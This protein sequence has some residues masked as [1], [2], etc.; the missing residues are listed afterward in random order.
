MGQVDKAV[1][2]GWIRP[3]SG[4]GKGFGCR[5]EHEWSTRYEAGGRNPVV[6]AKFIEQ[7]LLQPG[8]LPHHPPDP[9]P[10]DDQIV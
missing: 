2:A 9:Q 8:L 10:L 6:E 3:R 5:P 4:H 7:P 1:L